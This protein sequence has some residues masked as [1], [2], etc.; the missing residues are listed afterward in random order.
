[1]KDQ[2]GPFQSVRRIFEP[3]ADRG[4]EMQLAEI[5][6]VLNRAGR[7]R[8]QRR[9]YNLAAHAHELT[10]SCQ[11]RLP[12]LS[13]EKVAEAIIERMAAFLEK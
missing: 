5:R 7:Q 8:K 2:A 3:I 10:F 9:Q 11:H 12:L 6:R 1:M 4:E 13:K